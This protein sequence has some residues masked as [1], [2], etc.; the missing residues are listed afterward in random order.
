M[1]MT[2]PTSADSFFVLRTPLLPRELSTAL[3]AGLLGRRAYLERGDLGK[4]LAEDRS[5]ITQRLRVLLQ[6]PTIRE[7]LFVASPSLDEAIDAWLAEPASD[8]ASGV[9]DAVVRYVARMTG[10]PTPFGLFSGCSLGKVAERTKLSLA[11]R[12]SYR[13]HVRLDTSYLVDLCR[14]LRARPDLRATLPVRPSSGLYEAGGRLRHAESCPAPVSGEPFH[15]LVSTE[16]TEYLASTIARAERGARPDELADALVASDPRIGADDAKAYVESLLE[17]QILVTDLEPAV[18]GIEPL[19]ELVET[20][21]TSGQADDIRTL[22]ERTDDRLR[23]LDETPLGVPPASYR[24]LA[25]TLPRA[26]EHES[27]FLVDLFKPMTSATLGASVVRELERAVDVLARISAAPKEDSLDRFRRAFAERYGD[28]TGSELSDATT[29]PLTEVLDEDIGIGFATAHGASA[30]ASPLL[31]GLEFPPL[32]S[33]GLEVDPQHEHLLRLL[34]RA[35]PHRNPSIALTADDLD[36][37]ST[38]TPAPLPDSF[39]VVLSLLSTSAA[40]LE[41]GDYRLFVHAL[42]GPSG[43]KL[44]GRFCSGSRD[45]ETAVKGHLSAEEAAR[46]DV[47][48]AEVAHLPDGRLGNIVRRPVLRRYEIAYLGR[49][50]VNPEHRISIDDLRLGL[51]NGRLALYSTRLARE[52]VPRLTSAHSHASSALPMYRFLG[53]LQYESPARLGAFSW[54]SLERA[55]FLPRVSH[56][57]LV[58]SPRRWNIFRDQLQSLIAP[59]VEERFRALQRLRD[60]IALPRWVG[61]VD[62]ENALPLDLDNVLHVETLAR[63]VK[64]RASFA[65]EESLGDDHGIVDG[66]EGTFVHQLVVPFVAAPAK[67]SCSRETPAARKPASPRPP[68][69]RTFPPGSDWLYAKL[70]CGR[71]TADEILRQVAAPAIGHARHARAIDRWFFVRYADPDFHI[72]LRM[73]GEARTLWKTVLPNLHA[74]VEPVLRSGLVRR[75]SFDTYEREVVRYGDGAG[76]A[77]SEELFESDSDAVLAILAILDRLEANG[78]SEDRWQLALR[79]IHLLLVDLGLDHAE[80]TDVMR[81]ARSVL[82][83]EHRVDP[84]LARQL[85]AKYRSERSRIDALVAPSMSTEHALFSSFEPFCRRSERVRE[86]A[87][88]LRAENDGPSSIVRLAPSYVHMFANRILRSDHR[89]Q[90]LVLYDFLL[91]LYESTAARARRAAFSARKYP[92]PSDARNRDIAT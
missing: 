72:R 79:G 14:E 15:R 89:A 63:L 57:R 88:R 78:A 30:D 3:G 69:A 59:T 58:L 40:A 37:L 6:E 91:R 31:G 68:V 35:C 81:H 85:G 53:A 28:R 2:E 45:L 13:R 44:L 65:L 39:S 43:A 21:K 23:Q 22:L 12:D 8:R 90:E 38:D 46:P 87:A 9:I 84:L 5:A 4:A 27:L 70:Y 52:I 32:E 29:V 48:Y 67:E 74:L 26:S 7:A 49:S 76:I 20:L 1:T 51:S 64:G 73:H 36:A 56:G 62:G 60:A 47:I 24:E 17:A 50:G 75:W 55:P 54:G 66:P 25:R 83:E 82:A 41:A 86:I 61:A 18:T 11:S 16:R 80:R 71:A 33:H 19:R 77:L 92:A 42:S 10:R 34:S